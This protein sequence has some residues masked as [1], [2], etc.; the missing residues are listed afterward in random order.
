ML[1]YAPADIL[2]SFDIHPPPFSPSWRGTGGG[3]IRYWTPCKKYQKQLSAYAPLSP[4]VS[5]LLD[6]FLLGKSN[7]Y[8]ID[9]PSEGLIVKIDTK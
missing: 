9:A 1:L 7:H 3:D 4:S 8:Q 2:L 5:L 6:N